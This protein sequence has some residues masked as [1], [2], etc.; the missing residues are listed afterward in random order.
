MRV[1]VQIS[2]NVTCDCTVFRIIEVIFN[3]TRLSNPD[4]DN[5]NSG[6]PA[7]ERGVGC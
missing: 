6:C 2:T 5:F 3:D 4:R 1:S 7:R